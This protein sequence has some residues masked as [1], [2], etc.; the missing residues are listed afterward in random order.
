MVGPLPPGSKGV[1]MKAFALVSKGGSS[2]LEAID[3]ERPCASIDE[4]FVRVLAAGVTPTES[5]PRWRGGC[6]LTVR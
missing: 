2:D 5:E 3:I 1:K 4:L 6:S